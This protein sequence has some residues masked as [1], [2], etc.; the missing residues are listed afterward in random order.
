MIVP[1]KSGEFYLRNVSH[2]NDDH[3]WLV[4]LH[5]DPETLKNVT[6]PNPI[7]LESHMRWWNKVITNPQEQRWIFCKDDVR[8]GFVK[9]YKIDRANQTCVLGADIHPD[10]RGKGYAKYM[11][12]LLLD[13][14]F[15]DLGLHGLGMHRVSLTTAEY[16][17]IGQRVYYNLGFVEE[18]RFVE[19]L[20]R[21][22]DRFDEVCM[23]ML[24]KDW[25]VTLDDRSLI[26][27]DKT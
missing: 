18:G 6:N 15:D 11:W 21:Q 17:I 22:G 8:I 9:I 25:I 27:Y 13:Y 14:C 1:R 10:E 3:V 16:N 26:S 2:L 5:N 24:R 19:S 12:S 20:L 7:T 23:Y 4:D